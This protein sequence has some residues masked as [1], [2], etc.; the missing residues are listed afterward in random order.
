M[1]TGMVKGETI[2]NTKEKMVTAGVASSW[3]H[4]GRDEGHRKDWKSGFDSPKGGNGRG[5]GGN[6]GAFPVKPITG[7]IN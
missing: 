2:Q 4:H 5:R 3:P 6:E 7:V 1:T